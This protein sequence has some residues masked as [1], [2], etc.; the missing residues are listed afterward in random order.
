MEGDYLNLRQGSGR[1]RDRV[2]GSGS[3]QKRAD[4]WNDIKDEKKLQR[5]YFLALV[6]CLGN[7]LYVLCIS[8]IVCIVMY[9]GI[10]YMY[11]VLWALN[12]KQRKQE[13]IKQ[14]IKEELRSEMGKGNLHYR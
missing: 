11:Y 2:P 13:Q 9:L 14:E 7:F 1:C 6:M 4:R 12:L 5:I 3:Q 8:G 10:S